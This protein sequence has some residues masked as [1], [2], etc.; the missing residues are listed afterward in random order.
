MSYKPK[1]LVYALLCLGLAQL[2]GAQLC[3]GPTTRALQSIADDY[4]VK[5]WEM[6]DGYLHITATAFA[7]TRDGYLWVGSYRGLCRFDGNTFTEISQAELPL[8]KDAMVLALIT[9]QQGLLWVGTSKGVACK[10][11]DK[12]IVYGREQGYPDELI[13]ALVEDAEGRIYVAVTNGIYRLEDGVFKKLETP[14]LA[15][16]L[17]S[18]LSLR[19]DKQG[20]LWC[21]GLYHLWRYDGTKWHV[22]YED[23][24]HERS[25]LGAT[26][27][28]DGGL[29]VATYED[30]RKWKDGSWTILT[31]R[32]YGFEGDAPSILEDSEGALWIGGFS[33]GVLRF[34]PSGKIQRCTIE[35]GLQN[36]ATL[37]VFEDREHNVWIGSNGGGLARLRY[38]SFHVYAEKEGARQAIINT[39]AQ[40]DDGLVFVGT[41]GGGVFSFDGSRF[42][43]LSNP[44]TKLNAS[45]AWVFSL[46]SDKNGNL[47]VGSYEEGAHRLRD[48]RPETL[49]KAQLG[50]ETV[51][52]VFCDSSGR[53]WFGTKEGI[54]C[55]LPD[56]SIKVYGPGAGVPQSVYH[57]FAE[58]RGKL[59]VGGE[60][61]GP[62]VL[63]AEKDRFVRSREAELIEARGLRGTSA[64]YCEGDGPLFIACS[65]SG[66]L[67]VDGDKRFWF[68]R[69]HGLPD[70]AIGGFVLDGDKDLWCATDS[71]ILRLNQDSMDAVSEGRAGRLVTLWFD[72]SDGLRSTV[73][74]LGFQPVCTRT[75]EGKL[76]FGTLKGLAVADPRSVKVASLVPPVVIEEMIVDGRRQQVSPRFFGTPRIPAGSKRVSLRYTGVSLGASERLHFQHRLS[77]LDTDWVEA[78]SSRIAQLQDLKPGHYLFHVRALNKEGLASETNIAFEVEPYYWQTLWFKTLVLVG[79]FLITI[80]LVWWTLAIRYRRHRE[81]LEHERLLAEER[82]FSAQARHEMLAADAANKAKSEFLAMMS[83]EIRTPLNGV[84]ASTDLLMETPLSENQRVNMETVRSSAEALLSLINDLLDFS[85]IEA[86]HIDLESNVFDPRTPAGD[87]AR[88]LWAKAADKGIELVFEVDP[89]VPR[90]CVG[91]SGRLRQVLLNLAANAVKFTE[92]GYVQIRLVRRRDQ[93]SPGR[94]VL[95]FEVEDTGIGIPEAAMGHL[96]QKF[97]QVD[98]STRRKYGGT[99]LG[100]AISKQLVEAMGGSIGADSRLGAGSRFWFELT[101]RIE[102]EDTGAGRFVPPLP[103]LLVVDDLEASRKAIRTLLGGLGL[104]PVCVSSTN[105]ALLQLEQNRMSPFDC[106]LVDHS[107]LRGDNGILLGALP[108][109]PAHGTCPLILLSSSGRH[110]PV[111]GERPGVF[112]AILSKPIIDESVVRRVLHREKSA[113]SA[114]SAA[115]TEQ[116]SSFAGVPV[117]VADDNP[118]NREVLG[119]LLKSVG[120]T[121]EFAKDGQEAVDVYRR[122]NVACVFMDCRMPVKDGFEAT[123]EIRGLEGTAGLPII[124]VTANASDED[125]RQCLESGMNDF[126]SKPVLKKDIVAVL[127][128]W[129]RAGKA[130]SDVQ[131]SSGAM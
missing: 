95:R 127:E 17:N 46:V 75:T 66:I 45:V 34:L 123:R 79:S 1:C 63:D 83:H 106:I 43:D 88:I 26:G 8:L 82:A 31:E 130:P 99:G 11:G 40:R 122:T 52:A 19:R 44:G 22:E 114:R 49:R 107:V 70:C 15:E 25:L 113:D 102:A 64:L 84:I 112:H 72:K 54:A 36:N 7:Q 92:S 4:M 13:R 23:P 125:R 53:T 119:R 69:E 126:L 16:N 115:A 121:V 78:G 76:L 71:G 48:G 85:K 118:V 59:Y 74:R 131:S 28:R 93:E 86:G 87:V 129:L 101:L 109:D 91:D 73:C 30:I 110:V 105:E 9:D 56:G 38:R 68:G 5:V 10:K 103:R 97:T 3:A 61:S 35:D 20:N 37:A 100:L 89:S 58:Y 21:L 120:C 116:Q 94:A 80:A 2:F 12:W 55:R 27:S 41:H 18:A 57:A 117:L 33:K 32:P 108:L 98:S 50:S 60:E 39:V 81:K 67:R 96:F 65:R 24:A 128:R 124:A 51:N 104:D 77:G 29:W 47:W 90:A 111:P 62:L 14:P 6:E 42:Q